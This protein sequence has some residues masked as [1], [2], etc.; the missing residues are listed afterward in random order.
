MIK[1]TDRYLRLAIIMVIAV[2]SISGMALVNSPS[3][4][5]NHWKKLD[6]ATAFGEYFESTLSSSFENSLIEV[7]ANDQDFPLD[8]AITRGFRINNRLLDLG[9]VYH[10]KI[11]ENFS[12]QLALRKMLD[13]LSDNYSHIRRE[14]FKEFNQGNINTAEEQGYVFSDY[15]RLNYVSR[16]ITQND[17]AWIM[18]MTFEDSA[19]ESVENFLDLIWS[20]NKKGVI[21]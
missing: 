11:D 12:N 15:V 17:D 18:I 1:G 8:Q 13:L 3:P 14:A 10:V 16:I 20:E 6:K 9:R 19:K 7:N 21:G 4:S 5:N 2:V